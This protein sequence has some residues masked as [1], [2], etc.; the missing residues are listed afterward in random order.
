MENILTPNPHRRRG[1]CSHRSKII[2][3]CRRGGKALS[4]PGKGRRP[5]NI[6]SQ[7]RKVKNKRVPRAA[8]DGQTGSTFPIPKRRTDPS[9]MEGKNPTELKKQ[10][11]MRRERLY[12]KRNE[13]GP[14]WEGDRAYDQTMLMGSYG[15]S[16][17][18]TFDERVG[19]DCQLGYY[20]AALVKLE[21]SKLLSGGTN[22]PAFSLDVKSYD[23]TQNTTFPSKKKKDSMGKVESPDGVRRSISPC[24]DQFTRGQGVKECRWEP[25]GEPCSIPLPHIE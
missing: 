13:F 24:R 5:E 21:K 12:F 8:T 16:R 2:R 22:V 18:F 17:G 25:L 19:Q 20:A 14:Y 6:S 23:S 1:G 9:S 15:H 7:Q 4:A 10:R 3:L 11:A